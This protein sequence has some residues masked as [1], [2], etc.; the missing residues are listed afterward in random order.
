MKQG[1]HKRKI[2]NIR[3]GGYLPDEFVVDTQVFR[4]KAPLL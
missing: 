2:E 1:G 3:P 4:A